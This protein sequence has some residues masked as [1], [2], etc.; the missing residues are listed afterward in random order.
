MRCS[1]KIKEDNKVSIDEATELV[2]Q[3]SRSLVSRWSIDAVSC[4]FESPVFSKSSAV[5]SRGALSSKDRL[6]EM[7]EEI[8][9]CFALLQL[10]L[11]RRC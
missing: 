7:A 6:M 1:S 4:G 10:L 5:G 9:L 3:P 11:S 2:K 8:H